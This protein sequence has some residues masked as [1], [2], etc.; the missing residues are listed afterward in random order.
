MNWG[1]GEERG[2]NGAGAARIRVT[3]LR[4]QRREAEGRDAAPAAQPACA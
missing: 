4:P 1:R 2:G 3:A